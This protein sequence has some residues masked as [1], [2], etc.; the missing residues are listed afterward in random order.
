MRR[1]LPPTLS[2]TCFEAAAHTEN[3]ALAAQ[4]VNL[5]ASAFSRQIKEL[6]KHVGLALFTRQRQRVKLTSTGAMLLAELTPILESLEVTLLGASNRNNPY[7]AINIGTYPTLGSRWLMPKISQLSK[8][9]PK[10]SFNTITYLDNNQIDPNLVDI[11]LVQGNPP[12]PSFRADSLMPESLIVVA[13]PTLIK[14]PVNNA[15]ELLEQRI[16]QHHTRPASWQIWFDSLGEELPASPLGPLFSQFEMLINAVI[17]GLGIAIVPS[18]LV[19]KEL[20]DGRLIQAHRYV[21]QTSSAYYL[22]TPAVKVGT[23]R[24]EMLRDWLLTKKG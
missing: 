18:V 17:E 10:L 15:K 23:A 19:Q 24:I 3:F 9:Q 5:S 13:A 12:W 21:A 20:E 11:A 22:L 6:E 8:Q 7:G 14:Q 16:L 1:K 2:L 4:T